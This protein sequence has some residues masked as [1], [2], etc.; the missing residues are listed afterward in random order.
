MIDDI[1]QQLTPG[2]AD[3]QKLNR[4]R[5]YLQV[6]SLKVMH[7]RGDLA[8]MAFVGGTCLRIVFNA[9]RFSE[10][11]DF[12]LIHKTGYDFA[13]LCRNLA[14]DLKL[15]GID[16]SVEPKEGRPVHSTMIKFTGLL[17]D[18]GLSP[19]KGQKL[20]IKLEI[21]TNPPAGWRTERTII[22]N[23]YI[24]PITHYDLP[25]LFAGKLHA[26][27]YRNYTKGRDFY[28]LFWYLGKGVKPNLVLL[29][30]AIKQTQGASPRITEKNVRSFLHTKIDTVDLKAAKKDVERFLEDTSELALFDA[31]LLKNTITKV[32]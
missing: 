23:Q 15:R 12:S 19:L 10:D 13:E 20:S 18:L 11:M 25:S 9:R 3:E 29:N 7:D 17:K 5:E 8:R 16:A 27:F 4:V 14:R 26:C 32:F 22:N 31:G 6:L 21:D 2:M 28:D 30:N 1:R 24:F